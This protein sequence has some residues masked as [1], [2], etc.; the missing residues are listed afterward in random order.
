M[1]GPKSVNWWHERF[2]D[3]LI[4]NP[5]KR[6]CD[7]AKAFGCTEAWIYTLHSSSTFREYWI[8]RSAEASEKN[9]ANTVL[10]KTGALAELALDKLLATLENV[11]Q[12]PQFYLQ[13][14]DTALRRLGQ[15]TTPNP[16]AA[17]AT[18][19]NVNVSLVTPEHL[20][21]A[22]EKLRKLHA[23]DVTPEVEVIPE[24]SYEKVSLPAS[25]AIRTVGK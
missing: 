8:K 6:I 3:W 17:A 20:A 10:A 22:R 18:N 23:V 11:P 12:T 21:A 1:S 7:A 9:G 24:V 16:S 19:V 13:A 25:K 5:D 2:A 15:G 14:A 4:L